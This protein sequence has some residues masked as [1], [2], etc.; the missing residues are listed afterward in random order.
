MTALKVG[1]DIGGTFTDIIAVDDNGNL[2]ATKASSTPDDFSRGV[3]DSLSALAETMQLERS[4]MLKSVVEFVNGSTVATNA[5][6]Q[7]RGAKVGLLVTRGFRDV[8][9][10]ARSARSR[11]FDLHKQRPLPEIVPRDCIV[12]ISERV[13]CTG[14]IVFPLDDGEVEKA[15][16]W[17]VD[18]KSVE[19]LAVAFLW[20][21]Q[22]A[23]HERRVGACIKRL[24]PGLHFSLSHEIHPVYREYER[25]VTTV[26]NSYVGVSVRRYL[27]GLEQ[28][29]GNLGLGCPVDIM[30]CG[31]GR[32]NIDTAKYRPIELL[33]SGPV[34]GAMGAGYLG[35]VLEKNNVIVGDMGGTSFDTAVIVNHEVK[36][37]PR[38]TVDGFLTGLTML[39]VAS[40]GAG[41]GSIAW[42]DERGMPRVGPHSAGAQPG[43]AC[44]GRG[45]T[46]PTIT[47]AAVVLGHLNPDYF[48]GGRM[49]I[50]PEKA[51]DVLKRGLAEPLNVSLE[52]AAMGARELVVASM[53]NAVRSITVEQGFD[54][55]AFVMVT[56]GGNGPMFIADICRQLGITEIVIPPASATFSAYGLLVS[57]HARNYVK[58]FHWLDDESPAALTKTFHDLERKALQDFHS[59]GASHE[60]LE[61][62]WEVDA[63]FEGQFFEFPT[64]IPRGELTADAIKNFRAFFI[65]KYEER[66]GEQTAWRDSR[67]E[68]VNC[69]LQVRE[70][71]RPPPMQRKK[72]E[73]VEAASCVKA[74]R[75]AY[76]SVENGITTVPIYDGNAIK[77]GTRITGGGIVEEILTTIVIPS[78]FTAYKDEY[79]NFILRA[80]A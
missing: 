9:R 10:I 2:W 51:L 42:I 4:D 12:E 38:V 22:N 16:R 26:F 72:I 6:A 66:Y 41:G 24:Y 36:K 19:S 62:V 29:L 23:E 3:V 7:W 60:S 30:Q 50:Y 71:K 37:R 54:P 63:R 74:R 79:D 76:M 59:L 80:E 53:S 70:P 78:D 33:Q 35:R 34:A 57:E 77:P 40:V 58:T 13:D 49:S 32:A 46:L 56:Y 48:L 65:Q 14:R 25:T 45:G 17:L 20:S 31:G 67:I 64:V 21:F 52:E 55:R 5:I 75:P 28:Q 61:Y 27:Q 18:E 69:R 11:E 68:V 15:V 8:L 39:D 1:I 73:P 47:D 44:Y 43:P